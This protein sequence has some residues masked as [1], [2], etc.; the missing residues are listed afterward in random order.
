MVAAPLYYRGALA[1]IL[2]YDI[3]NADSFADIKIWL[4]ELRQNMSPDLIIH[5]V[6]SKGDLS[7]LRAVDL[8]TARRSI[9]EWVHPSPLPD[10]SPPLARQRSRTL[11]TMPL[12][13]TSPPGP[14][15]PPTLGA[16]VRKMST[17]LGV[18][19]P[20]V[21]GTSSASSVCEGREG[22]MVRSASTL[23]MGLGVRGPKS[24]EER[25]SSEEE[26]VEEMVRECGIR[27]FHLYQRFG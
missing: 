22:E 18:G 1:A 19:P 5:I 3:T 9:A 27:K 12:I 10:P 7:S 8:L 20:S 6:G 17:K 16:R 13:T 21:G 4:E 15:S 14:P 25:R 11:S 2:V 26:R 24:E 23:G